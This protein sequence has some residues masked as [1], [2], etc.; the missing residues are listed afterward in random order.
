MLGLPFG[1]AEVITGPKAIETALETV[2]APAAATGF[3]YLRK[4]YQSTLNLTLRENR[5]CCIPLSVSK[6][7]LP[8]RPHRPLVLERR[9]RQRHVVVAG[10]VP[11]TYFLSILIPSVSV[12][13]EGNAASEH[14][15]FV[16]TP[17]SPSP[18][19]APVQETSISP[20]ALSYW[21]SVSP[22]V[23]QTPIWY[24]SEGFQDIFSFVSPYVD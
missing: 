3:N 17:L 6:L 12:I 8:L 7:P 23:D 18:S 20:E 24:S 10:S 4:R 11:T 19:E 16:E 1:I 22:S 15:S 5:S 21:S 13:L 9:P 2:V 14:G